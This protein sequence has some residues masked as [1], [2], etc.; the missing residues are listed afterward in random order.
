MKKIIKQM[1]FKNKEQYQQSYCC[2][3][4]EEITAG[5]EQSVKQI[6]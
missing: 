3:V 4:F 2:G 6:K 5:S 1:Q